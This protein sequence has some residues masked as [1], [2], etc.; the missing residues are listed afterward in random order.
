MKF[1]IVYDIEYW[2][3][4]INKYSELSEIIAVLLT[5]V[6]AFMPFL[7]LSLFVTINVMAFGFLKGFIYSLIGTCIGSISVFYLI[8]KY[9]RKFFIDKIYKNTKVKNVF[10]WI[11]KE[12][13]VPVF[14]LYTFPFTPSIIVCGLA[15]VADIDCKTYIYATLLGK[16]IMIF[17]MSFIG[18]N[19][20]SFIQQ[21]IRASILILITI[22]ISLIGKRY[23]S[24][25]GKHK[26]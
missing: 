6:E 15:A 3:E 10:L 18:F 11:K 24:K 5:L 25:Y 16:T 26:V 19:L 21:P 20:S 14:V 17:S 7:P 22:L 2:M 23:S 8:R 12:G 13:F 9:G 4:L 1:D